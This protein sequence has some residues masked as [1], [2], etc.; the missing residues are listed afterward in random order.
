MPPFQSGLDGVGLAGVI[1]GAPAL[2]YDRPVSGSP[3]VSDERPAHPNRSWTIGNL[4]KRHPDH[5]E[6]RTTEA[7]MTEQSAAAG[8][9]LLTALK[10]KMSLSGK[11]TRLEL[12]GAMVDVGAEKEGWLHIS[13]LGKDAVTRVQDILQLGQEITVWV[14]KVDSQKGELQLTMI[15]PLAH[16]WNELRPG[17][18]I[19]GKIT[20][21]EKFGAFV[22]FGAERPG[23][24]HISELSNE[25]V[26]DIA[27]V[28]KVGEEIDAVILEVDRKKKQV[29][30]SRKALE[31]KP[32]AKVEEE[33]PEEPETKSITAMEA[34]FLKAQSGS[35]QTPSEKARRESAKAEMR[36]RQQEE[37]LSRTLQTAPRK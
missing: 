15:Q 13:A 34:A 6:V 10:P 29:H 25:Y 21:I 19:H 4:S 17:T 32:Q 1:T 3:Q 18:T 14:R 20:R 26:K 5:P 7:T 35:D 9:T 11:V 23:L 16:D 12:S 2:V 22:D 24:I 37:I 31:T 28:A 36:R 27:S 8:K 30:L 33:L